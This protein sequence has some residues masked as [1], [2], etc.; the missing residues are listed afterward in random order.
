M[1][2]LYIRWINKRINKLESK[3]HNVLSDKT[4]RKLIAK[5]KLV[6]TG[7]QDEDIQPAS[8]DIRIS[9][10]FLRMTE[11]K[12]NIEGEDVDIRQNIYI[13]KGK[14]V[15][16]ESHT[17]SDNEY[18]MIRPGEFILA[19]AK[20]YLKIPDNIVGLIEGKYSVGRQGLL[21]QNTGII[22]PGYEGKVTL[23]LFNITQSNIYIKPGEKIAQI[24]LLRIDKHA[25]NPYNKIK[26]ENTTTEGEE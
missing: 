22:D 10:D 26:I 11:L 5:G 7:I 18:F 25:S 21:I 23:E 12:T 6:V 15:H 24:M 13:G 17:V 19:S 3:H 16:Y 2:V 9:N 8:I 1:I 4:I 14:P 20:S